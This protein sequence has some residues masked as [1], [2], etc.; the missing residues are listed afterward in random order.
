MK[1][2][3][4]DRSKFLPAAG[5][6]NASDPWDVNP[7]TPG[8]NIDWLPEH[9]RMAKVFVNLP[10]LPTHT[11]SAT[12]ITLRLQDSSDNSNWADTLPVVEVVLPGIASTGTPKQTATVGFPPKLRRYAR[13]SQIADANANANGASATYEISL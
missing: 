9:W 13:F 1:D 6:N 2:A 3:F 11:N 7:I 5:A 8:G 10:A 12:S 4:F